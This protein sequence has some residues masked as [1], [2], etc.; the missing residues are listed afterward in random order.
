MADLDLSIID[1]LPPGRQRIKTHLLRPSERPLAYE[2]HPA[3]SGRRPPG[4]YHLSFGRGFTKA[5]GAGRHRGIRTP[6]GARA[7]RVAT[8]TAARSD[9]AAGE[10]RGDAT[11]PRRGARRTGLHLGGRVGVDVPNAT[12][13]LIEGAERFGLAQLHQFRAGSDAASIPLP[14]FYLPKLRRRERQ[15][16]PDAGPLQRWTPTG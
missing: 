9:E 11:L 4:L 6:A 1:E 10:G 12:V 15:A 13:M 16:P 8:G 5:G 2:H 3:R 14:V 7:G